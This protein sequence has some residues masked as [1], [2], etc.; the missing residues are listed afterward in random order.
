M[1]VAGI[2]AAGGRGTRLGTPVP[3]QLLDL[4]GRSI[5][6]RAVDALEATA[7]VQELVVVLPPEWIDHPAAAVSA[8]KPL[9]RVP[10]GARRQES[11]ARGFRSV[12]AQ[13]EIVV[14][15]DAARPFVTPALI[16]RTVAA[17][18]ESGAAVAALPAR[19][20][21]KEAQSAP[22][23]EGARAAVPGGPGGGLRWVRRTLP[24]ETIFLAQTPQAFRRDV[25]RDALALGEKGVEATDEAML[26]ELAGH[27]VR[28]VEGDPGNFKI[29]TEADLAYARWLVGS[30]AGGWTMRVGVGYDV[31]RLVAG[32]ALVLGGVTIP[33]E[34]G[35]AGH[36][37]GDA[38]CHAVIDAV[39]GAAAAGDIGSHFPDSD[40]R[41]RGAAS[42]ELVRSVG[43]KVR[44][45]GFRVANVDVV[46]MLERPKIGPYVAAMRAALAAALELSE[47][48]ISVKGKTQ[49]G[50]GPIGTG[51]AVAAQA[52]ALLVG[53][54]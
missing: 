37:D 15:H 19:D 12:S 6:Q 26:A 28:L 32:R 35:P 53:S 14:V 42:V 11:V 22:G 39:L 7:G 45:R 34:R 54:R 47:E 43:C 9:V 16:E 40:E 52:V 23:V 5:L 29:T 46:V 3:K 44:D 33:F 27:P 17:A 49:E 18:A 1:H 48:C 51:D 8:A 13:A 41:W 25:L 38:V 4:G 50:L 21:V 2:V 31:H 36:S 10:G 24:R 30:P 20:T